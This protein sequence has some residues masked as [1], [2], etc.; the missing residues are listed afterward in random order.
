MK[1]EDL[2][3]V[4]AAL[5]S[6]LMNVPGYAAVIYD[7]GAPAPING[8][9]EITGTIGADDFTVT[10]ATT[11]RAVRFWDAERGS[12]YNGS[13][14]WRIYADDPVNNQPG[15]LLLEG[16]QTNVTRTDLGIIPFGGIGHAEFQNDFSVSIPLGPGTYWL[17][18]HNG[19]LT[20][21]AFSDNF[22]WISAAANGTPT[23]KYDTAPFDTGGWTDW[24]DQQ[25]FVLFDA[26]PIPEPSA[27]LLVGIALAG[28]GFSR[29]KRSSK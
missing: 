27:I 18:L 9:I 16:N 15:L 2:P 12:T 22:N 20:D 21:T 23:A 8:G 28:L 17:G 7:N 13:I 25:A 5:F 3:R 11:L 10:T 14:T 4:A 29:R 19:P 1:I 24:F 6:L 26:N